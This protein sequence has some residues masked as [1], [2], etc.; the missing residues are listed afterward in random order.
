MKLWLRRVYSSG[1]KGVVSEESPGPGTCR[2][3]GQESVGESLHSDTQGLSHEAPA[4]KPSF[5]Q[6]HHNPTI[7]GQYTESPSKN[8][9]KIDII[10]RQSPSSALLPV[11]QPWEDVQIQ[12]ADS[13]PLQ[14]TPSLPSKKTIENR[15]LSYNSRKHVENSIERFAARFNGFW[16]WRSRRREPWENW[17]KDSLTITFE[18]ALPL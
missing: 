12:L 17:K 5:H 13:P 9:L 15:L 10:Y 3:Q 4:F 16:R 14:T 6:P 18:S 7:S 8:S 1:E 2:R 11:Y